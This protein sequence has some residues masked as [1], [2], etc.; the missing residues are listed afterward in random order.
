MLFQQIQQCDAFNVFRR[1]V[2]LLAGSFTALVKNGARFCV[3]C[4]VGGL[5]FL[6]FFIFFKERQNEKCRGC[7]TGTEDGNKSVTTRR[8]KFADGKDDDGKQHQHSAPVAPIDELHNVVDGDHRATPSRHGHKKA[9]SSTASLCVMALC[10]RFIRDDRR[11]RCRRMLPPCEDV[12]TV[13][14]L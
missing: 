9:P 4:F 12:L 6:R 7:D 5:C 2:D 1:V 13:S 14:G 11:C 8:D 10:C 3:A